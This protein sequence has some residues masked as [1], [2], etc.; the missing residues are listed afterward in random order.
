VIGGIASL[1]RRSE[2]NA[3]VST[4]LACGV[5]GVSLYDFLGTRPDQWAALSRVTLLLGDVPEK[6]H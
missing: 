4:A 3:F 6:C 2:V 5:L 1:A